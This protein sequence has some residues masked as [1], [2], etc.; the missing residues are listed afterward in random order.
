[1]GLEENECPL[2]RHLPHVKLSQSSLNK[3][4]LLSSDTGRPATS[5]IKGLGYLRLPVSS[6]LLDVPIS[7]FKG[8]FFI[9]QCP[10]IHIRSL[11]RP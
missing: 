2:A 7:S 1:M 5:T 9:S 4:K 6:C 3:G 11:E 10:V 8:S